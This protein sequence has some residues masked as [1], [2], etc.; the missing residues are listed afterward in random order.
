[1][2]LLTLMLV[3][4]CHGK[5]QVLRALSVYQRKAAHDT[6]GCQLD[7]I[8]PQSVLICPGWWYVRWALANLTLFRLGLGCISRIVELV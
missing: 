4:F 1:M 5:R 3:H 6:W 2:Q 7:S 8:Y